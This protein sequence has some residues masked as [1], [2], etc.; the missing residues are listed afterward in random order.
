VADTEQSEVSEPEKKAPARGSR[1]AKTDD[2]VTPEASA[3][4]PATDDAP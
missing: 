3:E 2:V 1:S 4:A